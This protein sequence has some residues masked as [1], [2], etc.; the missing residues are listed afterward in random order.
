MQHNFMA[1]PW[2]KVAGDLCDL[3]RR[4]LL[5]VND[6]YSNYIEVARLSSITSR[7]IIKVRIP[8]YQVTDNGPQFSAAEYS[9]FAKTNASYARSNGKTENA[10]QTIKRFFT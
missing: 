4:T 6:C 2:S 9:M 3:D 8:D 1:R 5:V 10:V 7:A